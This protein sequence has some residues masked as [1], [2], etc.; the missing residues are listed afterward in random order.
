MRVKRKTETNCKTQSKHTKE[1]TKKMAPTL[2]NIIPMI[3]RF[4]YPMVDHDANITTH[5]ALDRAIQP[6]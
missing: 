2:L 4:P 1:Q 5:L 3:S 6:R